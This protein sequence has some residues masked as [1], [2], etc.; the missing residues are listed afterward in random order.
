MPKTALVNSDRKFWE[1]PQAVIN[2]LCSRLNP[3]DK[4]LEIGPGYAPFPRADAFVD[5]KEELPNIPKDKLETVMKLMPSITAP[6]VSPLYGTDWFAI[7][8][9]I[10][11]AVVRELIPRL[12]KLGAEGIIEYPLNKVI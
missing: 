7:E 6:T 1:P 4:V 8:S 11:E 3:S 2:W 5:A 12:L 9:V 10:D